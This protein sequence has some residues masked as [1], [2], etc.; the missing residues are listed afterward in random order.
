MKAEELQQQNCRRQHRELQREAELQGWRLTMSEASAA[1]EKPQ[2]LPPECQQ[3]WHLHSLEK[4]PNSSREQ[5]GSESREDSEQRKD[6]ELRL[7]GGKHR[8]ETT[9]P[10]CVFGTEGLRHNG[11][12]S[13]NSGH[14]S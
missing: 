2:S 7:K 13:C 10:D 12:R 8:R 3:L 9:G 14:L 5:L 4:E 6:L 11:C 1:T